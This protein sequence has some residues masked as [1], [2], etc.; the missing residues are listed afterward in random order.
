MWCPFGWACVQCSDRE[1]S[2]AP[3]NQMSNSF[4]SSFA[5]LL[6]RQENAF[7]VQKKTFRK[8]TVECWTLYLSLFLLFLRCL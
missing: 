1:S 5:E 8:K 7:D 3:P 2:E 4:M 6:V